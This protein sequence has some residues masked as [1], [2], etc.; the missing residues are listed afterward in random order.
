MLAPSYDMEPLT[1]PTPC[2]VSVSEFAFR[3]VVFIGSL[4]VMTIG[5]VIATLVAPF[6]GTTVVTVG[7]ISSRTVN[8]DVYGS[9]MAF[10]ARSFTPLIEIETA[11][12]G[13]LVVDRNSAICD[14]AVYVTV[15]GI[16]APRLF[17]TEKFASFRVD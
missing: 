1:A 7:A 13:R 10:P 6:A 3:V 8:V 17:L 9:V 15:P 11:P 14:E 5:E 4:N 16:E 2:P 12:P